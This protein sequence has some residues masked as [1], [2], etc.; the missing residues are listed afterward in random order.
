MSNWKYNDIYETWV[1][2]DQYA[3]ANIYKED[4]GLYH[5]RLYD[6]EMNCTTLNIDPD[7]AKI[8]KRLNKFMSKK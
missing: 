7:I 6:K 8:K 5:A 1:N 3:L 4:S 2:L